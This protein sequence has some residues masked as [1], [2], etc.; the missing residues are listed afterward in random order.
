MAI[1]VNAGAFLTV[2][3]LVL[4][5]CNGSSNST[6]SAISNISGD[7]KGTVQDSAAGSATVTGTLAQHGASAGGNMA[8]TFGTGTQ[9]A[10]V[11][12][13]IDSSN[14]VSGT[15][16]EDLPG[17]TVCTF[18]TSGSYSTSSNQITGSYTAV[19]NCSGQSGTY[20]L[21]QQC[22]DTVTSVGRRPMGV[23]IHC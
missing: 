10:S 4:Q 3:M 8:L 6:P 22:V 16:V 19:T 9:S 7:Y 21:T 2:L 17:G 23:P 18:S 1:R 12:L 5:G 11:L 20:S 15:I 13:V 14:S